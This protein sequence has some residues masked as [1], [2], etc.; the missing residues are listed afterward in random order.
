MFLLV[1]SLAI[2]VTFTHYPALAALWTSLVTPGV[3]V[4]IS[5][6][7]TM[8]ND[9]VFGQ[10]L[11]NTALFALGTVPA[12]MALAL[13]MAVWVNRKLRGRGFLRLA[14]FTP[15]ILPVVATASI[16]LFFFTPGYGPISRLVTTLGFADQNWLGDPSTVLPSLMVMNIWKEAGFLM[17]FYLAGLQSIP[18]ELDEASGLEGGGSWYNFRRV[19]F[20]LLM[21][22][23]LFVSVISVAAALKSID[24]LFIM[25]GGGP[26]NASTLLLYYVYEV[27]FRYWDQ[28]Y[29]S[30]LTIVLIAILLSLTFLQLKV[31]DRRIHYR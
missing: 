26:A 14:Y 25:T 20:P 23:T 24:F 18:P 1:P 13:V 5:Q 15:A 4:S 28:P 11:R 21:P 29:A 3:G 19:T 17:I 7:E 8:V 10:A 12:S 6:F 16:W 30:A 31:V 27:A 22:T 9:P 2:L